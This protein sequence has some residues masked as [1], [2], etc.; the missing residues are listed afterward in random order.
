[1]E[2]VDP[3][4]YKTDPVGTVKKT[5]LANPLNINSR[6]PINRLNEIP[7]PLN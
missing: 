6:T 4:G 7:T 5:G 3:G 2:I 1:M